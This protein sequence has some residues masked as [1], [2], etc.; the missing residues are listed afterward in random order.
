M[1]IIFLLLVSFITTFS[2]YAQSIFKDSIA[3]K[4]AFTE[5]INNPKGMALLKDK[6]IVLEFWSTW[7][8]PCVAA[9]PHFNQL[10]E[11]YSEDVIFIS[12]NSYENKAIVEKFLLEQPMSSYVALDE[13]KIIKKNFNIQ[14][15]PVT[16]IID[17][18]G[19][20][21]WRGITTELTIEMLATFL[22][23]NSF[24]DVSKT[25]IILN[26]NFST[27]TLDSINYSLLI[28]YGD[29]T[30]G[31]GI[32]TDFKDGFFLKLSN[33]E[34]YSILS[35][36]SEWLQSED[37]WKYEGDFPENEIMNVTIKSD[38]KRTNKEGIRKIL[39]D[40]IL[41]LSD[42]LNFTIKSSE[43]T[44]DIWHIIPNAS[45]LE[46]YLSINQDSDIKV[47]EQTKGFTKYKNVFFD[48]LAS[49]FSIRTKN[50]VQYNSSNSILSYDL[51]IPKTENILEMKKYLKEKYGIDLIKK[52]VK[53]KVKTAI[54]NERNEVKRNLKY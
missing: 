32:T 1:K 36:I 19:M 34:I 9:I 28:D 29:I 17:K 23:K 2:S 27:N 10:V 46:K 43:E 40:V 6:P 51:T 37:S 41:R 35:T 44:Q 33:R 7:C 24:K 21:R 5:W 12:I 25:G 39:E 38:T 18:D 52:K 49:S 50:N 16:I 22:S 53:V 20:L 13:N 31:K 30:L 15:I 26:Q 3:P 48:F 47:I 54:F 42:K 14:T 8:G 4:M 45:Q 11:K